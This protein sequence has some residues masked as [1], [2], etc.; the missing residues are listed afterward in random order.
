M[1]VTFVCMSSKKSISRVR[2]IL[3][4]YAVRVGSQTWNTPITVEALNDVYQALR[5]TSTRNTAV[6][7]YRNSGARSMRLVWTVGR[8][9][10]FNPNGGVAVHY[11]RKTRQSVPPWVRV[12]C[13][14]AQTAGQ[15]HDIGKASTR[16]QGKLTQSLAGGDKIVG[17]RIRHEW[18]SLQV[19]EHWRRLMFA[20]EGSDSEGD[21]PRLS[22]S[23]AAVTPG[24][25]P[26][27]LRSSGRPVSSIT[28]AVDLCTLTHHGLLGVSGEDKALGLTGIDASPGESRHVKMTVEAEREQPNDLYTKMPSSADF[29]VTTEKRL[30]ALTKR[31][32][33]RCLSEGDNPYYAQGIAFISR[34]AL[35]AADHQV[36]SRRYRHAIKKKDRDAT[37]F[38]NTKT[39]KYGNKQSSGRRVLDQPLD[40]HLS[41]V[42]QL[43]GR[44]VSRI[45]DSGSDF[46]GLTEGSRE[47]L[48]QKTSIERFMWQDQS[49]D[50][51]RASV[52]DFHTGSLVFNLAGTGSG[53]TLANI[54]IIEALTPVSRPLRV[55]IGLN[56]R[57]LTLQTATALRA[58]VG[59]MEEEVGYVVGDQFSR[60]VYQSSGVRDEDNDDSSDYQTQVDGGIGVGCPEWFDEWLKETQGSRSAHIRK[61]LSVPVLVSTSDYLVDAGNP[62]TQ[63]RHVVSMM[64]LASSDLIL[65]EVDQYDSGAL[66][67]MSRAIQIS[68]LFNRNVV[69]SSAT[70]STSV[71]RTIADAYCFGRTM[72]ASLDRLNEHDSRSSFWFV[73]NVFPAE[74]HREETS[75]AIETLYAERTERLMQAVSTEPVTRLAYLQAVSNCEADQAGET[76]AKA[77]RNAI[78]TLHSNHSVSDPE[79]G[80]TV[81]FGVVRV[82][83]VQPAIELAKQLQGDSGLCVTVYHAQDI[84]GRRYL[85]ER[86]FDHLFSRS[87]NPNAPLEDSLVQDI[88]KNTSAD[89]IAFVVIATPVEEVGRDHDFDWAVIEPSS[90]SGIVQMAGRVNRHRL[91]PVVTPN[92]AILNRNIR[93][94]KGYSRCFAYPGHNRPVQP[95]MQS[96]GVQLQDSWGWCD[97]RAELSI[98]AILQF[99]LDD[100]RCVLAREDE[101]AFRGH[102]SQGVAALIGRPEFEQ[103]WVGSAFYQDYPLRSRDTLDPIQF[104]LS[105]SRPGEWTAYEYMASSLKALSDWRESVTD[106]HHPGSTPEWAHW[107]IDA[108]TP[109]LEDIGVVSPSMSSLEISVPRPNKREGLSLDVEYGGALKAHD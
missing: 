105:E 87:G 3:D 42:S 106:L 30:W 17:D 4:R 1:F 9:D 36:S 8:K 67:A 20:W 92:I 15:N 59:L 2:R 37:L 97:S 39:V 76:I 48:L 51:M 101:S 108:I 79:S 23:F 70:L 29:A 85:K 12:A 95:D 32:T 68:A 102:A 19:Y 50:C 14:V 62:G 52:S 64:R 5:S 27:I 45:V 90:A 66:V 26:G 81:S 33:D 107:P 89:H 75:E 99:G 6:A 16:F 41:E 71:M 44:W 28:D 53:K 11:S 43:S 93:S 74:H 47:R 73:D 100:Q 80:K 98:N 86:L 65:D 63:G 40:W 38:A 10:A 34:A 46:E 7:C 96:M 104:R 56:L 35:I 13:L 69:V 82:A 21:I 57:S 84:R 60:S 55:S 49:A 54:K 91:T 109:A 31:V 24:A 83:N 25:K 72:R 88:L 77:V 61:L 78:D 94:L 103:Q 22:G 58:Q 18:L